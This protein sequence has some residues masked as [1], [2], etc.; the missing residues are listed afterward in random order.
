MLDN[1]V[2]QKQQLQTQFQSLTPQQQEMLKQQ[3]AMQAG[4]NPE[5]LKENIQD[6]YVA[7]RV[8]DVAENTSPYTIAAVGVPLWLAAAQGM[9]FYAKKSRGNFEDTVHHKIGQFGDNMVDSFQNSRFGKS[10]F[11]A[12]VQNGGSRFKQ[13]LK[14]NFVDRFAVTRAFAHTPSRP[15]LEMVLG[16]YNGGLGKVPFDTKQLDEAFLKPLKHIEDLGCYGAS[17][18]DINNYKNLISNAA[19]AEEKISLLREAEFESLKKY[20]RQP[21]RPLI[22]LDEFRRLALPQKLE[23]LK[24]MKAFEW[25]YR[26]FAHMES[27]GKDI[28]H[29]LPAYFEANTKANPKMYAMTEGTRAT[30]WGR[31]KHFLFGRDVYA[32]ETANKMAA[33]IG[34]KDLTRPEYKELGEALKRTGYDKKIPKSMFGKWLTKYVNMT[35]EATTSRVAGGKLIAIG[36]IAYL[37]DV[38]VKSAKAEGGI[39]EKAKSFAERFSEL[40]SFFI[41]MPLAVQ[42]MHR[43]GGLQYA[44]MGEKGKEKE[45]VEAYR[46]ALKIHNEKAMSGQF[47]NYDDWKAS[48]DDLLKRLRLKGDNKIK[49][50]ITKLFKRIGRI[51]TVGLEQ[52]RP[53]DKADIGVMKDGKKVYRQGIGQKLRDLLRHPKFGFKQMMGYPMRI[54]L[55]MAVLLPIFNKIAVKTSHAIFGRPKNSL[56]D[57]GKEPK[58]PEINPNNVQ[59]PSQLQQATNEPQ[60][61]TNLLDKYQNNNSFNGTQRN[62]GDSYTYVPSPTPFKPAVDPNEPV[63]NYVPS[64]MGA[65]IVNNEDLSEADAAMKRA[66]NAEQL[67]LKTLKM[68]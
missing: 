42:L 49:N 41:C 13:F 20:S 45:A 39:G 29:Q 4:I 58:Q 26:D 59:V 54:V 56:L 19:T 17:Q 65:Q 18:A 62:N 53:F 68:G 7:N 21:G 36:A 50:P 63:R 5:L 31:I 22:S 64:P 33:M 67:A 47:S 24:D 23:Y 14:K 32:S 12:S 16:E 34:N 46:K 10:G 30:R 48:Q 40:L 28:Q 8:N 43:I 35:L 51:V 27:I 3:L 1:N 9:D 6:T 2:N 52:I 38:I 55:G 66:D 57:E 15:E 37:A 44:G 25:G 61:S 60:G 11:W